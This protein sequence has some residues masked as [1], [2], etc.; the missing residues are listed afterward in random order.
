MKISHIN[1]S[2]GWNEPVLPSS[3]IHSGAAALTLSAPPEPAVE[4]M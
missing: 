1:A 3:R 2:S 4:A